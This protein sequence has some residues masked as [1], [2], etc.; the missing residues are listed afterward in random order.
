MCMGSGY[1]FMVLTFTRDSHIHCLGKKHREVQ[2]MQVFLCLR[3][4][5]IHVVCSLVILSPDTMFLWGRPGH[6]HAERVVITPY[7][8]GVFYLPFGF[9]DQPLALDEMQHCDFALAAGRPSPMK[10]NLLCP[11]FIPQG[12][13]ETGAEGLGRIVPPSATWSLV[14]VMGVTINSSV[15]VWRSIC[16]ETSHS[17]KCSHTPPATRE[18]SRDCAHTGLHCSFPGC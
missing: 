18:R 16:K 2:V 9:I 5:L 1:S 3:C 13:S 8:S 14:C 6:D 15:V 4:F 11:E 12:R 17:K 10:L 7:F